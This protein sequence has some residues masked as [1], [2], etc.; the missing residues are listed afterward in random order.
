M[1][2]SG[3]LEQRV[4]NCIRLLAADGVEKAK[5]GHPGMPLGAAD[6]AYVLWQKHLRFNPD[7]PDWINRDRFILSAGHGSMLLYSLLHLYGYDLPLDEL[8]NFRQLDSK[9]PGHP[10]YGHT[11]GVETTT[12]PLGQGFANAVGMAIAYQVLRNSLS[13]NGK[14]PINHKIYV[15]AGDGD[16]MEGISSEAASIAGHLNLSNLIVIYD[17][18]KITIEGSTGLAFSEDVRKR[19][20]ACNWNVVKINGHNLKQ[21]DN[22]LKGAGNKNNKPTIIIAETKIAKGSTCLEGSCKSHGSPLGEDE[23]INIKKKMKFPECESFCIPDDVKAHV[24]IRVDK[25]KKEYEERNEKFEEFM[26]KNPEIKKRYEEYKNKKNIDINELLNIDFKKDKIATRSASGIVM[27]YIAKKVPGFIGG[28]ADLGPSNNTMLKEYPS[29]SKTNRNGRNLH[30]GI[31]EHAMGAI[32]NGMAVYGGSVLPGGHRGG[33]LPFGATFLVFADYMRPAIRMASLMKLHVVYVFTHD[34]FF[35]GEDGPT[36]QPI[37]HLWS[38]RTIPNLDVVR[39][40]DARE[41][42][43]AWA[44]AVNND[45]NPTALI[46]TRQNIPVLDRAKYASAENLLKGAYIISGEKDRDNLQLIIIATGSEVSLALEV[47]QKLQGDGVSVRVVSM[48]SIELFER[49]DKNYK[50]TVL[51]ADCLK[52]VVIEAGVAGGWYKYIG[53]DG[54]VFGMEGFGTSAPA[55][56]LIDKFGFTSDKIYSQI[57][58]RF[59]F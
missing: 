39:P 6:I 13:K 40:A 47:Q 7:K 31:R 10:E 54:L 8:K 57:K 9:T 32:L 27:Q 46:L 29:F 41:T 59:D 58:N 33:L 35:V 17:D 19:F 22:A 12:G 26:D 37:E 4:T 34:S 52:K 49:Q 18:N 45:E 51:P 38:L 25:L 20:Q 16:M 48:P 15:I 50:K 53:A 36:H 43:A 24:K 42:A 56:V 2:R 14:S 23:I 5:S 55:N 21:I 30:F 44:Q 1:S 11:P 3:A 28:S